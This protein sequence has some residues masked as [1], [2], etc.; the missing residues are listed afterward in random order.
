MR[1]TTFLLFLVIISSSALGQKVRM[2]SIFYDGSKVLR[3]SKSG[4]TAFEVC[5]VD[6]R[7][8]KIGN[9]KKYN[10][11]KQL[12]EISNFE[13]QVPTGPYFLYTDQGIPKSEGHYSNGKKDGVWVKYDEEGE[14]DEIVIFDMGNELSSRQLEIKDPVEAKDE[15]G[16]PLIDKLPSFPESQ[17]GWFNHLQNNLRYPVEAKRN[18]YSGAVFVKFII[19]K[20]GYVIAPKVVKSPALS[21]GYEAVRVVSISPNWLPAESRGNPVDSFIQMRI[22][23]ALN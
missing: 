19:T 23:F 1:L 7:G 16:K 10:Q 15:E 17:Q 6:R 9:C 5:E 22:V 12:I 11:N 3:N 8:R 4:Y 20:E 2:D 13:M 18:G 21:L 14:P